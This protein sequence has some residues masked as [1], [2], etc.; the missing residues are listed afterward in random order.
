[1]EQ[2]YYNTLIKQITERSVESTLGVLS[3]NPPALRQ[4][5]SAQFRAPSG[6][7][8]ALLSMPVFQ[9]TFSWQP[10]EKCMEELADTLLHPSLI[11]AMNKDADKPN[12]AAFPKTQYPYEHQVRAWDVLSQTPPK[13]AVITTGTG[14][15]KTECFMVPILNDMAKEHYKIRQ[16]LVGVRALFIYPLNA[17]IS[18]QRERLRAWTHE[19]KDNIRFCLY[20]GLTKEII[21]PAKQREQRNEVLSRKELR[22]S[23]PP[24]LITNATMLEYMLIRGVDQPIL[25]QSQGMLRWI[26]L[27]EAHSYIGSRAAELSLLLRRVM[28]AFNVKPENIRFIATS[29]T[30]GGDEGA[31]NALKEYLA[32]L[33][34][35]SPEQVEVIGGKQ[36]IPDLIDAE[37]SS[38]DLKTIKAIPDE[39]ERYHALA[40]HKTARGIRDALI[41]DKGLDAGQLAQKVFN[42]PDA[43]NTQKII[44]WLDVCSTTSLPVPDKKD[45]DPFLPIRGHLFHRVFSGLWACVNPNCVKKKTT[46]LDDESWNFGT[47]YTECHLKCDCGAP[48]Y[49]VVFCHDCNAPHLQAT[50]QTN[51]YGDEKIL[52]SQ[53][54]AVDEFSLDIEHAV[55]EEDD[56]DDSENTS[57]KTIILAPKLVK[58][59]EAMS[60]DPENMILDGAGGKGIAINYMDSKKIACTACGYKGS[61]KKAFRHTRLGAPFYISNIAATLLEHCKEFDDSPASLPG[62]GR[63]LITFTDSRQG[64]ARIA[65]KIQQD[66]ERNR[67]RGLV[68]GLVAK[69][70]TA[71]NQATR[72]GLES[73]LQMPNLSDDQRRTIQNQLNNLTQGISWQDMVIKLQEQKDLSKHMQDYYK[74]M[75]PDLFPNAQSSVLAEILLLR[76]FARRPRRQSTLETMGLVGVGYAGLD[77]A[78]TLPREWKSR[79][80][81]QQDW[82]DFLKLCLDFYV[83]DQVFMNIPPGWLNWMAAWFSPKSLLPPKTEDTPDSMHKIWPQLRDGKKPMRLF[84]LLELALAFD[85]NDKAMSKEKKQD[86]LN[87]LMRD[88]WKALT[89]QTQILV[90]NQD[91]VAYRLDRANIIFTPIKDAWHCLITSRVLDTTLCGLTPYL[92]ENPSLKNSTCDKIIMPIRPEIHAS[93]TQKRLDEIRTWFNTDEQVQKLREAGIWSNLSDRIAEGGM[94][95][96]TAEHSAQQPSQRLLDYEARFKQGRLNILSCSTTMEMGVDI[97]GLSTVAMN[98]VPPHPTNYLQRAGRAGRRG[99]SQSVAMTVCRD[100]PH[101]MAVFKKPDWAFTTAMPNPVVTLNSKRIVQRHINA[102]I[103]TLFLKQKS[104]V[105]NTETIRLNCQ[106]FFCAE[107]ADKSNADKVKAWLKRQKKTTEPVLAEGLE[108]IIK[109]SAPFKNKPLESLITDCIENLQAIQKKWL[110][111]YKNLRE[112]CQQADSARDTDPYKRRIARDLERLEKEYLISEL[113]VRGFLPSYGFPIN[114]A[115][116]DPYTIKDPSQNRPQNRWRDDEREDNFAYPRQKPGRTLS[117]AI[118]EYAPGA[119]IVL[120][121]L[122]YKSEGLSLNWHIP[123]GEYD[124]TETQ[125]FSTAW[126]CEHCGSSG[127]A[128]G[129]TDKLRCSDCKKKIVTH[130]KEFIQPAGFATGFFSAPTNNVSHQHFIRAQDPWINAGGDFTSLPNDTGVYRCTADGHIFHHSAGDNGKGYC[131]CLECGRAES[132][133]IDGTPPKMATTHDRLRGKINI[134]ADRPSTILC[135]GPQRTYK[136]RQN[137]YIGCEDRTDMFELYLKDPQTGSY[138][139]NTE[140]TRVVCWTLGFALRQALA[141]ADF[142]GINAD[143]MGVLV[144]P[145]QIPMVQGREVLAICLYDTCGGGGGFSSTAPRFLDRLLDKARAQLDCKAECKSAC[146]HCL[147]GYDTRDKIDMLDRHK[148]LEFLSDDFLHRFRKNTR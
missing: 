65:T 112:E 10:H 61:G 140:D 126:R 146:Q 136:I 127:T 113:A 14:S 16:K 5:L 6:D 84:R 24:L 115:H 66:A 15:G 148:A 52:Q 109:G 91:T 19:Y 49:E 74:E 105:K 145:M 106:W 45:P 44:D 29:A 82:Q 72:E 104:I 56:E 18:S 128:S 90:P 46:A 96:R 137:L 23:P 59:V 117:Q 129:N 47:V 131:L 75:N 21:E 22:A 132:M 58:G 64:T 71:E 3:V 144:K 120:D 33:G 141:S 76:E 53:R 107:G 7:A 11:R 99:E 88:A 110:D 101:E 86:I 138:I 42:K 79:G 60:I 28:L 69:G 143:E 94:F 118:R 92:P 51:S 87:E 41:K 43:D 81:T 17:L 73:V 89:E 102:F 4:F 32:E 70:G 13:S 122:V 2:K 98:N 130:K 68:Y 95:F 116:F 93:S 108:A 25:E 50:L 40:R 125:R 62:R 54:Q 83:R 12:N 55:D 114:I 48:I 9:N 124:L 37:D 142:L 27:D 123:Q 38:L 63:R 111:E 134:R 35:I 147:L 31:E 36:A 139:I 34:G 80:K 135:D 100:N 119:D 77:K 26:V 97:G 20:N 1:M 57:E 67:L 121:G 39:T 133:L 78:T 30:I 103:L 8:S 85:V